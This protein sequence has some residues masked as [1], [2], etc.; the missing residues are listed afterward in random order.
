MIF[1]LKKLQVVD[2]SPKIISVQGN[3]KVNWEDVDFINYEKTR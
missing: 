3:E 1:Y 2:V